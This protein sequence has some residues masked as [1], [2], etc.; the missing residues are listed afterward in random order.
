MKHENVQYIFSG[1][2]HPLEFEIKHHENGGLEFIGTAIK[3]TNDFH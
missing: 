1:H 3:K 2:T